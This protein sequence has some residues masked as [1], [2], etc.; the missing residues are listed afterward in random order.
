MLKVSQLEQGHLRELRQYLA[1][2]ELDNAG[3]RTACT[4]D[5]SLLQLSKEGRTSNEGASVV[6]YRPTTSSSVLNVGLI[7]EV[8]QIS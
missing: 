6:K 2:G 4:R 1:L 5:S 7:S 8:A 3:T